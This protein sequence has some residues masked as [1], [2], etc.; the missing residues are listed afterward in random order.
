MMVGYIALGNYKLISLQRVDST[1]NHAQQMILDGRAV[2][3][4]VILADV[5]TAGR[6]RHARRWVSSSGN[7]YASFI[8][9]AV[10]RDA[11]LAY[12]AAV[13]VADVMASFGIECGIKWPNDILINGA[14]VCGILIEYVGDFAV[15]GVGINIMSAPEISEYATTY[16]AKYISVT[17]DAVMGQ[18][19]RALEKWR[20]ADFSQVRD[21]WMQRA[22]GLGQDVIYRGKCAQMCG[23]NADGALVLRQD[24]KEILVWGDEIRM[25]FSKK[26][27]E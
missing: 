5:Q 24:G 18:L 1:Q 2:D 10:P 6:G 11:R 14:K 25:N 15:L 16:M 17:R 19:M 4:T 27:G 12:V 7:L 21:A 13:A 8:F 20:M 9:D 23:I 26:S 22:L 3:G